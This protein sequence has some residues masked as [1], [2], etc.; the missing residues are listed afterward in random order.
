MACI[1]TLSLM[2]N[3]RG[4]YNATVKITQHKSP[5]TVEATIHVPEPFPGMLPTRMTI[6][7]LGLVLINRNDSV[8]LGI[9]AVGVVLVW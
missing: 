9:V 7:A 5:S 6:I 1:F 3:V 4:T 2:Q 8:G